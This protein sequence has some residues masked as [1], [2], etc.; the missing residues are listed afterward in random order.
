MAKWILLITLFINRGDYYEEQVFYK[1]FNNRETVNFYLDITSSVYANKHIRTWEL[2]KGYEVDKSTGQWHVQ[3]E[4]I[5]PA[6][7]K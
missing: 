4:K 6:I 3:N 1:V 7:E 2:Y 5:Y